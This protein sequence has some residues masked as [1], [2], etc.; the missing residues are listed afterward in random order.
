MIMSKLP[1]ELLFEVIFLYYNRY[2]TYYINTENHLC[3]KHVVHPNI[4]SILIQV[5][6]KLNV[7]MKHNPALINIFLYI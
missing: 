4:K 2:C 7:L 5:Y 1:I 6:Y 3:I